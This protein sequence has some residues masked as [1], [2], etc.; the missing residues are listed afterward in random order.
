[1]AR[2]RGRQIGSVY[3]RSDGRWTAAV[4][5]GYQGGKRKRRQIYGRTQKEVA[6]ALATL[7]ND[8]NKGLLLEADRQTVKTYLV[9]WLTESAKPKLRA[10]TYESYS[11]VVN[12]HIVPYLG[13]IPMRKL[14]PQHVQSLLGQLGK[15]L[16]PRTVTYVRAIL[17]SALNRALK[18]NI[19][20]RNAASLSDAPRIRYH[21]MRTFDV[22]EA[23]AFIAAAVPDRIG[24]LFTVAIAVGLRLG[25]ALGVSWDDI[26]L[27]AKTLRVCRALQRVDGVLTF[28]EPKSARS[29]RTIRLP[30]TAVDVLRQHRAQQNRERLLAGSRWIDKKLV[31]TSTIGTPLDER[32]VRR[33]FRGICNAAG[34]PVIRIHDLRHTCATLL[35]VQGV[36]ARV[37]MEILGHSQIALTLDTYSHVLPALGREAADRMDAVLTGTTGH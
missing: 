26:D 1:M 29:R 32:N 12:T 28:V 20:A 2:R 19:V 3:E 23:K 4:S 24:A 16:S 31:F 27:E 18:W 37:V 17:R 5:V 35:L 15:K 21:E 7:T 30:V 10:R 13:T 11:Q 14:T 36:P 8:F 33:A 9:R 6:D 25:E 22:D 34:T